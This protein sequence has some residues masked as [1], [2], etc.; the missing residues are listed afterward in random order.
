MNSCYGGSCAQSGDIDDYQT[1]WM[2]MK[3]VGPGTLTCYWKVSSEPGD[4]LEFGIDDVFKDEG[5]YPGQD[6]RRI[7]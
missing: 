5:R 7:S 6:I 1:S 3:V 2:E 4:C